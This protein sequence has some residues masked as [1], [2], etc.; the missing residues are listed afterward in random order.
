MTEGITFEEALDLAR[1]HGPPQIMALVEWARSLRQEEGT[2]VDLCSIVNAL[3]GACS[4]DC[5]FCAQSG[6]HSAGV[7]KYPMM[8]PQEILRHARAAEEAGAHH[9]CIVT[10][11]KAL[12]ESDF[13]TV[14]EAVRL[15]KEETDLQR[16][17][18][19]GLLTPERA[20]ALREAGLDRFNHNLETSR[21]HFPSIVTTHSYD[22]RV[23]T[24]MALK[25]ADIEACAGCILNVGETDRQR[26]ELAFELR[27][28]QPHSVPINF[29]NPRPGTRL[30]HLKPMDSWEALKWLAIVRLV[31]PDTIIRLAG[32]RVENLG[33]LQ[34]CG[35]DAGVNGL[36]IGNY[37]TTV[38]PAPEED[39][40]L[41]QRLGLDV[42]RP[43]QSSALHVEVP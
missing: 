24:V 6:H 33:E 23:T 28:L 15:I 20:R 25:E 42:S 35:F 32:G 10:A 17:A 11:G 3:S 38:G 16:C 19:L 36:L 7:A 4:E 39:L 30:G 37:L 40:A 41:L 9:F 29:L 18:S 27:A 12:S 1:L 5:A 26:V 22:D 21:S 13:E 43:R 31:M 8:S 34:E 14:L 2:H